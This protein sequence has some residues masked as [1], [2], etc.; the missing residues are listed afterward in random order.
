MCC[1]IL[2]VV[3]GVGELDKQFVNVD[4]RKKGRRAN[5]ALS[6]C[7]AES[8]SCIDGLFGSSHPAS[9]SYCDYSFGGL[10]DSTHWKSYTLRRALRE[11]R[12]TITRENVT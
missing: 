1:A 6:G 10:P 12:E 3:Q 5:Y 7:R 9:M 4:F 8:W 11:W 2:S